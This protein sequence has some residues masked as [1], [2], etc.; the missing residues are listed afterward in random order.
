MR[1]VHRI[2]GT[3]VILKHMGITQNENC[4]FCAREKDCIEHIFWR[5]NISRSF[6][7]RLVDLVNVK[8]QNA[9][10]FRLS[11]KLVILGIDKTIKIDCV[12]AFILVLAKQY[13][14]KCKLDKNVPNLNVF[15]RKL[16]FRYEVEKY[17]AVLNFM[18]NE[19]SAKWQSYVPLFQ[20]DT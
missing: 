16:L 2:L 18:Y 7:D 13:L 6:W 1:I 14:Y 12:F 15:R 8:C 11:E 9:V 4:S 20:D 10:N 3:N 17:N 5:C 19:F